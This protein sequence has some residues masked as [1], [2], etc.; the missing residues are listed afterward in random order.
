MFALLVSLSVTASPAAL[1]QEKDLPDAAKKE[2]KKLDGKWK[3]VKMI[4]VDGEKD[5]GPDGPDVTFEFKG[6]TLVVEGK[7]VAEVTAIDSATDPKSLDFKVKVRTGELAEG[8]TVE[9]I[10]KLD[11]DTLTMAVYIGEGK[12]RPGGFD[13]PKEAGSFVFVFKRVKE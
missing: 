12:K 3:P 2:L 1:P 10:Y 9:A 7:E 8:S 13:A 11:G 5:G 4:T 6:R